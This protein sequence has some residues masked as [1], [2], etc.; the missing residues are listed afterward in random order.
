MLEGPIVL[1]YRQEGMLTPTLV[2]HEG[3]KAA[4]NRPNTAGKERVFVHSELI[5]ELR[6]RRSLIASQWHWRAWSQLRA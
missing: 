5:L 4:T 2:P 1:C 6:T 3:G